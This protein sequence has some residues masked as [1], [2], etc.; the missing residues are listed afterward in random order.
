MKFGFL[1]SLLLSVITFSAYA[2]I[3]ISESLEGLTPEE[4]A[5][6][7]DD[8]ALDAF[9]VSSETFAWS[10]KA[11]KD[12]YWLSNHITVTPKTLD[13]RWLQFSQCHHQLDPVPKIEVAY[14]P[15]NIRNLEVVSAEGI[16]STQLKMHSVELKDVSKGAKVCIQGESKTAKITQAGFEINRGPYMRRFLDGYYPM[17]VEE[18]IEVANVQA[19]L[20]SYQPAQKNVQNLTKTQHDSN[21][22]YKFEYA[23]EGQ[24]RSQYVFSFAR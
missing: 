12:N 16:E 24:L 11:S 8:S 19:N 9:V 4:K 21:D 13:D 17:I 20:K 3:E 1:S 22:E 15:T 6:L 7:L 2:E 23:F 10:K 18:T 5:W 14:H